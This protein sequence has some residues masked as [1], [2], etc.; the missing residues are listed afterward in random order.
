MAEVVSDAIARDFIV[1]GEAP[2]GA[3]LPPEKDLA[4]RLGVSRP[5]I[6]ES[7]LMLQQA[8]LIS[9]RH[10]VGSLVLLRPRTVTHGLD[11]LCSIETFAREAGKAV[12]SVD[13]EWEELEADPV[14]AARLHIP[15]G[16]PV[17]VS[18]RVK[19]YD[20]VR[21]GWLVD[22]IPAGVLPFDEIK[23]E[24]AGS[25]L[26]VLL[27]H[28]EVGGDFADTDL[29]AVNLSAEIAAKLDVEPG[30]AAMHVDAVLWSYDG[31]T[32]D[33]AVN[34][35]LPAYFRFAVRRRRSLGHG[36]QP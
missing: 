3:L 13:V 31:R 5:T 25:A 4:S 8:G 18:R 12:G 28:P 6:R 15:I 26:D 24:F 9:I 17:L 19:I 32:L 29:T 7:L 36:V 22:H 14:T 2:P 11:Q 20:G 27:D 23:A 35:Y 16:T 1:S 10:G 33:W 30:E 34:W 21:V